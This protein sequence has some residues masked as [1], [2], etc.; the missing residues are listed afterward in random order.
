MA[1]LNDREREVLIAL[2]QGWTNAEIAEHLYLSIATVKTYISRLL[3]TLELS[4]R[5]QIALFARDACP[6]R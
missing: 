4:N 6:D 1:A 5:T 2:G 3:A